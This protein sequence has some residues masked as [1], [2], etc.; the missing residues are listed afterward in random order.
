M[1]LDRKYLV[2][3]AAVGCGCSRCEPTFVGEPLSL[4]RAAA[5]LVRMAYGVGMGGDVQLSTRHGLPEAICT[6]APGSRSPLRLTLQAV[7]VLPDL[8]IFSL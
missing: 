3:I 7:I 2:Q 6:G 5:E 8:T 4:P 1:N